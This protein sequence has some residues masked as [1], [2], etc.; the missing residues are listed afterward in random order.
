M[1]KVSCKIEFYKFNIYKIYEDRAQMHLIHQ[2]T[3][4]LIFAKKL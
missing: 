4:I 1:F 3:Q 2:K